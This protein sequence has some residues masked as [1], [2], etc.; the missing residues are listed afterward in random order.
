M[1]VAS[2]AV[3][4][5]LAFTSASP[6]I[7]LARKPAHPIKVTSVEGVTEYTLANGLRVLT[8][9]DPTKETVTLNVVYLVGSRHEGYGE[10][11]MA[12]LLE[13][14]LFKGSPRHP[15]VNAEMNARGAH[16]NAS[17]W[18]DRTHY[19]ETFPATDANLEWAIDFEADRM[20]GAFLKKA[21]LDSEMTVVR[22]EFENGENDPSGILMERVLSTAFLWHNYGKSTIGARSDIEN[23]P[24][25]RLRGF[26]ERFYQPD[27]AVVF[28]TGRFDE[29]AALSLIQQRFGRLPRPERTLWTTWTRDPAQDGERN[30]TLRRVGE[31]P[32]IGAV[33]HVPSASHPDYAAVEV[34][35]YVLGD[36]PSGR[37]HKGLV[38][39]KVAVE[40]GAFSFALSEPSVLY[41]YAVAPKGTTDVARVRDE[42]VRIAESFASAPPTQEEVE[43]AIADRMKNVEL[44][45]LDSDRTGRALAEWIAAGDWRLFFLNRDRVRAVKPADVQRVAR[46]YLVANNRTT[47]VFLPTKDAARVEVPEAP[48]V[49]SL[50]AKYS[51]G[52]AIAP[53]EAFD[54]DPAKID[55]RTK[56]VKLSNGAVLALLPKKTRGETVQVQVSLHLGER[57][58]LEGRAVAG[59]LAGSMLMRGSA[60]H[61]RQQI[62]DE[63]D[64][65]QIRLSVDATWNNAWATIECKKSQLDAALALAAELLREPAFSAKEL[66]LLKEEEIASLEESKNDPEALAMNALYRHIDTH[67]AE[68]PRYVMTPDEQIAAMRKVTVKDLESF[69]RDFF[70]ASAAEI[71]FVGDFDPAWAEKRTQ[72]LFG[73]WKAKVPYQRIPSSIANVPALDRTVEAK[74]KAG[75]SLW[76]AMKIEM[77]EDDPDW[78]A[79]LLGNYL[80]GATEDARLWTRIR[81]K[82]GLSYGVRSWVSAGAFD[83]VG[84]FGAYGIF[85]P[86]NTAKFEAALKEEIAKA[87]ADGFSAEEIAR[88]K[89]GWLE[90]ARLARARDASLAT[91]LNWHSH[92]GRTMAWQAALEKRVAALTAAD[93]RAALRK[94]VDPA[95]LSVVRAGDYSKSGGGGTPPAHH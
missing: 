65:L 18:W 32:S 16:N 90:S 29:S 60:R 53:G 14:L 61:S 42:A 62:W 87:L 24:I 76:S 1:R 26:Y 44:T 66:E 38:E 80:L 59:G 41:V 63:I 50:V 28:L 46:T 56:R 54:P 35:S 39:T 68:D 13:H 84:E 19:Y 89:K 37:L 5:L 85:A 3:V 95:K 67:P 25:E 21:D 31:V 75:A 86:E 52:K 22:N 73:D 94:H 27:N 83:R 6:S 93:I 33:W 55:A 74:D 79:L 92:T 2:L 47:G 57:N 23:V 70:G 34:L 78:P 64:R 81:E 72:E 91:T 51:G 15:N 40:A 4:C 7:A 17:T 88:A 43:R 30:V 8:F 12:H 48:A 71:A 58:A 45:L 9:P 11:G 77:Q 20:T 36:T 49:E 69:H 82:D 10:T